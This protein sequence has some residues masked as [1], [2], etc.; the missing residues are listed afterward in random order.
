MI[1]S[2]TVLNLDR[3][4]LL[5]PDAPLHCAVSVRDMHPLSLMA[6][7]TR[8]TRDQTG[9]PV[10][11]SQFTRKGKCHAGPPEKGDIASDLDPLT[12][13]PEPE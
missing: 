3:N 9:L 12:S 11:E 8:N 4:R 1:I 5:S 13:R 10:E 6:A 7:L 2:D